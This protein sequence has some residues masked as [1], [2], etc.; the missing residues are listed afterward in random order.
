MQRQKQASATGFTLIE[1]LIVIAI[2]GI[3]AGVLIPTYKTSVRKAN[4]AAAIAAVNTIK[5]AQAKYVIDK[6][7]YGTFRQLFE[8]RY[9]DKRF[10]SDAPHL[11]GYVFVVTLIDAPQK[12]GASFQLN[13][14]PE[15][16]EGISA[17]GEYFY[18]SEPD[19]PIF[20]SSQGPATAEDE[21]L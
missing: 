20:V 3:L 18:Y 10:N 8:T 13:A 15:I 5:V 7:H 4:E 14:N 12:S 9:L 11:R 16:S 6:G 17:T 2:I 1:L 21:V 19:T